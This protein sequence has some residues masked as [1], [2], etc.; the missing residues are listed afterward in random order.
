MTCPMNVRVVGGAAE[1]FGQT[2][3]AAS[4][5]NGTHIIIGYTQPFSVSPGILLSA[6]GELQAFNI[7][8]TSQMRKLRRVR[9]DWTVPLVGHGTK[10][11]PQISGD[12]GTQD[13]D[14]GSGP[15]VHSGELLFVC[16]FSAIEKTCTGFAGEVLSDD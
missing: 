4:N 13:F 3:A 14:G 10:P 7:S 11:I 16:F 6:D 12:P 5:Y 9:G 2:T 15:K 1:D 8:I